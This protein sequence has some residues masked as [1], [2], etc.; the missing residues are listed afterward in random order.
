VEL[1]EGRLRDRQ[2]V[3]DVA[4]EVRGDAGAGR[5]AERDA[6]VGVLD[7][8]VRPGD[9]GDEVR[10]QRSRLLE[11]PLPRRDLLAGRVG[12]YPPVGRRGH[13]QR[14]RRLEVGLVEAREH[15][16]CGVHEG[17]AVDVGPPVGGVDAA[18][19]PLAVVAEAHGR[20]DDELVLPGQ[21][22]QGEPAAIDRVDVD[23]IAV[24]VDG[25]DGH[26]LE[27]G[28]RGAAPAGEAD[29]GHRAERRVVR[30]QVEGDV[31]RRDVEELAAGLRLGPLKREMGAHGAQPRSRP[32][33]RREPPSGY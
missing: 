17:H 25:R 13:V 28:E 6:V 14:V 15:R 27:V 26:R 29:P 2:D 18:V 24:E 10:R 7:E 8:V 30:G 11:L 32:V 31:V 3:V 1:V 22:L 19:Q 9:E 21:R 16:R 4:V 20:V 33:E 5:E 12:E 23:R